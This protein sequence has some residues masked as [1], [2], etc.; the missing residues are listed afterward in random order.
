MIVSQL[1]QCRK[2]IQIAEKSLKEG[3]NYYYGI[4][5]CNDVLHGYGQIG[6]TLMHEC[7]CLR[8]ALLLKVFHLLLQLA[9]ALYMYPFFLIYLLFSGIGKMMLIWL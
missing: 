4:E 7:L 8:A 9:T 1:D 6:H 2:L 3:A 5:A